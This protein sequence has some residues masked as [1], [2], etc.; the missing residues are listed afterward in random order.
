MVGAAYI[1]CVGEPFELQV[2]HVGQRIDLRLAERLMHLAEAYEV[3]HPFVLP[4]LS[5]EKLEKMSEWKDGR[6]GCLRVS[7]V[8][9]QLI[10]DRSVL[11]SCYCKFD[12]I[13]PARSPARSPL[14]PGLGPLC[15][16]QYIST[17]YRNELLQ[18][19]RAKVMDRLS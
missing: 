6:E 4:T 16:V 15:S 8:V 13:S 12:R 19:R 2:V 17:E 14:R 7:F 18:W 11:P 3:I 5:P 10:V 1:V 9:S